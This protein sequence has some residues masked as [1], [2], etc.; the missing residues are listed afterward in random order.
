MKLNWNGVCHINHTLQVKEADVSVC[1]I[2]QFKIISSRIVFVF[3]LLLWKAHMH[4]SNKMLW[5]GLVEKEEPEENNI[6]I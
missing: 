4:N 6:W 5:D 2:D 1:F 3:F